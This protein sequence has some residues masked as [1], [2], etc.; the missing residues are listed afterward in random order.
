MRSFRA[1]RL[2]LSL[3]FAFLSLAS[4][5]CAELNRQPDYMGRQQS[6]NGANLPAI[7]VAQADSTAGQVFGHGNIVVSN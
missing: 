6:S 3:S 7:A 2:A 4:A 5:G 1:R